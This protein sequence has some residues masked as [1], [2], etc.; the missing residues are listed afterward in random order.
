MAGP[1]LNFY[2]SDTYHLSSLIGTHE[3]ILYSADM[4]FLTSNWT[5]IKLAMAF[6]VKK[7]DSTGILHVT[8]ASDWGRYNQGGRNTA[9]NALMYRSL[10]AGS[11]MAGWVK[12]ATGLATKW[13]RQAQALKAA[14]NTTALNWDPSVG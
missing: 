8:G 11:I 5:K 6:T 9:A 7:I 1:P 13:T 12:D 4:E 2:G 14:I 10:I 3:Y